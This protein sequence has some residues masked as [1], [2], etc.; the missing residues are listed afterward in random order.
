MLAALYGYDFGKVVAYLV[1]EDGQDLVSA[2]NA[3]RALLPPPNGDDSRT[4][5]DTGTERVTLPEV[6]A[7]PTGLLAGPLAD[8]VSSTILPPGLVAGA[9]LGA[10]AGLCGAA[11]LVMPDESRVRP[12]LWIPLVAPRGAGKTPAM[13]KAFGALRQLDAAEHDRYRTELSDW[14]M[15]PVRERGDMP[16]D[17]TRR[18]DDATLETVARWLDRGDGTGV[19]ESDELSGWLQ[20]IGQYKRISGDKGRWLAMWSAQPWRYQRVGADR[21]GAIGIDVYIQH[22]VVSVV[23]GIQPH[24]HPLLGDPDSGFRPRWLPHLAPLSTVTWG[25]RIHPSAEWD[26]AIDWLYTAR[27]RREWELAGDALGIWQRECAE[28]KRQARG[29]ENTSASAALDKSDIQCARVALVIAESMSP[30]AGGIIPA[31]AMECA[32][33]I[34]EYVMNCWRAL[35]GHEAFA[36][37]RR[38]EI[39]A[40]KVDELAAWLDTR[41]G[42]KATRTQIKE[43]A[44]AGVRSA[45]D[46][47]T[48]LTAYQT[49]YPGTVIK[50]DQ[51]VAAVPARWSTRRRVVHA[52]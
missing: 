25:S 12:V 9:G 13:D 41:N 45:A 48:L 40:R 20:S 39:L 26:K 17:T 36:L 16:P 31:P 47:E 52:Q 11:A 24:L 38:D 35:P 7:Y 34:I 33:A 32:T 10:L 28:W 5:E 4:S 3:A 1:Q 27:H 23:G 49:V 19:V 21:S 2:A 22:P 14:T 8:L 44:I 42:R 6:P 50:E 15:L 18:I 51:A 43:A 46:A 29:S 37:S 30:G